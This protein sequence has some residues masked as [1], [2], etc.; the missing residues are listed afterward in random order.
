MNLEEVLIE[1]R[2]LSRRLGRTPM[3]KEL[4]KKT[5]N[6]IREHF[7]N[8]SQFLTLFKIPFPRPIK[9]LDRK[10]NFRLLASY[11]ALNYHSK[12]QWSDQEVKIAN[13]L[14][15]K[16]YA[17]EHNV[18]LGEFEADFLIKDLDLII[19]VSNSI[20]HKIGDTTRDL[21][22]K[23]YFQSHGYK[24]IILTS[25]NLIRELESKLLEGV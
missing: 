10:E 9:G 17:W 3:F 23:I 20:W 22:K 15:S 13:Y 8:Y 6:F 4:T 21:R 19:E 5:R 24:V 18:R 25:D 16:G 14:S 11:A 1:I 2:A 12:G 7:R